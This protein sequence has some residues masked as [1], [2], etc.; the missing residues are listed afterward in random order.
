[1]LNLIQH[2]SYPLSQRERVGVREKRV[3]GNT[4]C[5]IQRPNERFRIKSG[6]TKPHPLSVAPS[7]RSST[8]RM[9][10]SDFTS[11]SAVRVL[12]GDW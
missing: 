8:R 12:F 7:S 4:L 9:F 1:M 11:S 10:S 3:P 5:T 6:M 2:L